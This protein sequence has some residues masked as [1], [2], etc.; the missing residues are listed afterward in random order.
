[1]CG[2]A[3]YSYPPISQHGRGEN[4]DWYADDALLALLSAMLAAMSYGE[5]ARQMSKMY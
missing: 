2:H 4:G 5:G 1:M 3:L